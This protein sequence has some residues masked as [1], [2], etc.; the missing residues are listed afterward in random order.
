MKNDTIKEPTIT[1]H[2]FMI[3]RDDGA[4]W[5]T[6][7]NSSHVPF[8]CHVYS[9]FFIYRLM[10]KFS[11]MDNIY[12]INGSA[13]ISFQ[14]W[15]LCFI[16][17]RKYYFIFGVYDLYRSSPNQWMNLFLKILQ[18]KKYVRCTLCHN[19][20]FKF[21]PTKAVFPPKRSFFLLAF[22]RVNLGPTI[23]Q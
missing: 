2:L 8:I 7:K 4:L 19:G 10:Q 14:S 17:I 21:P 6:N 18:E 16:E 1:I 15:D 13:N 12:F 20:P 9:S 3:C 11:Y 22:S 23:V 5:T